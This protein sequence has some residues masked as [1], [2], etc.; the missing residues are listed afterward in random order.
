MVTVDFERGSAVTVRAYTSS[1]GRMRMLAGDPALDFANTFHWRGGREVDF[2]P[3]YVSLLEWSVPAGLL[4]NTERDGLLA[5]AAADPVGARTAHEQA[6]AIRALWRDHLTLTLGAA[7]QANAPAL[8]AQLMALLPGLL[9]EMPLLLGSSVRGDEGDL[10]L[11][12]AR[13][14]LALVSLHAIPVERQIGRCEGDPC[15]GFF[16]NTSRSKPRRWCSMDTCGNRAK[17]KQFRTRF[18]AERTG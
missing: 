18:A 3:D 5:L 9:A 8:P 12:L 14:A 13:L 1:I 4:Q 10:R 17:V 15:G 2:I 16:L 11:P 6:L 7:G